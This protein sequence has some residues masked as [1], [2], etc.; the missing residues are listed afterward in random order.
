MTSIFLE[1]WD[2][3]SRFPVLTAALSV[4]VFPAGL[5]RHA[6]A[7]MTCNWRDVVR[8]SLHGRLFLRLQFRSLVR[9]FL[10]DCKSVDDIWCYTV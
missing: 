8:L 6:I 5:L 2:K 3:S 10:A 9:D 4:L 7:N 1:M